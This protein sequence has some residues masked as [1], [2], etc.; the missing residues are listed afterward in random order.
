MSRAFV[1]VGA[2]FGLLAVLFGAFGAHGLS[3]RVSPERLAIWHTAAHY[4]GWHA[5]TLLAL[6]LG[7]ARIRSD[8]LAR[9]AGG[10]L[11]AGSLIFSGSLFILVLSDQAAWGAV[12][13]IGGVLLGLGWALLVIAAVV[14]RPAAD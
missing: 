10:C 13:P 8:R 4:L 9:A 5:T 2:L 7:S 1:I 3:T 12:T 11:A 6:G 14:G